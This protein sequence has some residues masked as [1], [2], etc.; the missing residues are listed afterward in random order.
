MSYSIY[1]K[2]FEY[3]NKSKSKII[4]PRVL[5][6]DDYSYLINYNYTLNEL[7]D[8]IKRF[9]FPKCKKRKKMEIRHFCTNML[10]LSDKILK[11]QK[12]W[13]KYFIKLFNK[14]LGPSYKNKSISNNFE[15]FLTTEKINDINYYYYFSFKDKDNF[16]YTFNIVSI[17]SLLEKNMKKNP[18]N[19]CNFDEELIEKINK[20]VRYN[21]I[22]KKMIDFNEYKTRPTS[23]NDKIIQLFHHM[24][25]L[26]YYTMSSWFSD[27]STY[28]IRR[29]IYELYEIWNYRADLTNEMKETICPPRGNPFIHM[30]RNFISNYQNTTIF[31][32]RNS[33]ANVAI[34]IMEKLSYSA[35]DIENQKLGVLYILSSLTLVSEYARDA[36]PWLYQSVYHN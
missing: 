17:F 11:I 3:L 35:H 24:D 12:V 10:Y 36:M 4:S 15:D 6:Y 1:F 19:R 14:T 34:N 27:L 13:N 20:R 29:F 31:Y 21:I 28:K 32:S 25:H 2:E 5:K 16:V 26:G 22:L 23:M 30:P 18:Y 9:K 8:L 7:N 33:I